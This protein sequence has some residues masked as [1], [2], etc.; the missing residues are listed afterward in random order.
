LKKLYHQY[1][2]FEKQF[3][4]KDH[5]EEIVLSKRRRFYQDQLRKDPSDYDMWLS[6]I[7]LE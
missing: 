2:Q 7:S 4:T 1:I 6:L 3:G 5:M